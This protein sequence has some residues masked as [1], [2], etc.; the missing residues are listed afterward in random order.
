MAVVRAFFDLG[1]AED[2]ALVA[3]MLDPDVVWFGTRGGLDEDQVMRGPDAVVGYLREIQEPW[4]RFDVAVE[5]I[6]DAGDAVLVFMRETA[7]T[8]DGGLE[9]HSNTAVIIKV[10]DG[11]ILQMTGY[12]DRD[13]ALLAAGLTD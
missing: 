8:R 5:K 9:L 12:L 11:K 3:D 2:D 4:E 6:V 10:R 7:Q 1:P 13:E